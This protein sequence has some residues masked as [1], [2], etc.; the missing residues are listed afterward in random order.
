V[1]LGFEHCKAEILGQVV[2]EHPYFLLFSFFSA[3]AGAIEKIAAA[4]PATKSDAA[5][6][7]IFSL[8]GDGSK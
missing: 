4:R 1:A 5:F 7:A 6:M 8:T 2:T 3:F